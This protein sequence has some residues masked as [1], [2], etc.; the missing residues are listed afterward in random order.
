M[1]F[2]SATAFFPSR[3]QFKS[4]FQKGYGQLRTVLGTLITDAR[5]RGEVAAQCDAGQIASALVGTWD[6]LLLQVWLDPEFDALACSREFMEVIL[7]GL[8]PMS[9]ESSARTPA[10]AIRF[11]ITMSALVEIFRCA[12]DI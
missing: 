2:W 1:G 10:G 5:S 6:A 3:E 12:E 8:R 9:G 4:V 11:D 7:Q